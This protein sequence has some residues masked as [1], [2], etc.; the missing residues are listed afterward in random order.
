MAPSRT[1][2]KHSHSQSPYASGLHLTAISAPYPL[3]DHCPTITTYLH[4]PSNSV[5]S[6]V[7]DHKSA[8]PFDSATDGMQVDPLGTRARGRKRGK[9]GQ[10]IWPVHLEEVFLQGNI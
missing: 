3:S 10:E 5:G 6:P 7:P 9:D 1:L 8:S 2:R 4:P